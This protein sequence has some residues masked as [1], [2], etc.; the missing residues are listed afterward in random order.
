MV[1][2]PPQAEIPES[3]L[4]SL[5][6]E[7]RAAHPDLELPVDE[8]AVAV[9]L[10]ISDGAD[11]LTLPA[12]D[13]W[14]ARAA[15]TGVPGAVARLDEQCIQNLRTTLGR[16]ELGSANLDDALQATRQKLLFGSDSQPGKLA[17]YTA[18]GSLRGFVRVIAAREV[19]TL[20]RR[21]GTAAR[22]TEPEL[23][24]VA[25]GTDP[26][27]SSLR[28]R[29]GAEFKVAFEVAL[30][31]LEARQRNLLRHQLLDQLG[32][33]AIGSLYGVHRATAARWL[34]RAREDLFDGTV[35]ELSQ[36]LN[37]PAPEID[38]VIRIIGSQLDASVTRIL[39]SEKS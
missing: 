5:V 3:V 36:R 8:F 30:G 9:A 14:L 27:L 37:L 4:E 24:G 16:F 23:E 39:R 22:H 21:A 10:C 19:V 18:R 11:P 35:A 34:T 15:A 17:Q 38:S 33:D 25:S 28:A 6:A 29:Y 7:A 26:E 1:A 20:T 12:A 2:I 32:I 31:G 13:V